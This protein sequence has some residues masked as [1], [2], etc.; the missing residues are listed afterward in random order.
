MTAGR[1]ANS[2]LDRGGARRSR[3]NHT[4]SII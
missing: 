1:R 4:P 3:N 2:E